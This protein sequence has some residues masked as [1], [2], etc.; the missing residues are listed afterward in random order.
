MPCRDERGYGPEYIDNTQTQLRLD[1]ATRVA[2]EVLGRYTARYGVDTLS[3]GAQNWWS[4]HQAA[5]KRRKAKE[6]EARTR[7]R[8]KVAALAK[9]TAEERKALGL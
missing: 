7:Q 6:E 2:C 3:K 8:V 1:A 5:D 9:L 4:I